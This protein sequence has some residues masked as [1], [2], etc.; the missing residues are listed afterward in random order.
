MSLQRRSTAPLLTVDRGMQVLR[1][2]RCDRAAL[3]NAELVR[4]T[5]LPKAT[6]SRL[7]STLL[8]VGYLRHV[9]GG[10]EFEL[11]TG[12]IGIGYAFEAG[13]PL[14]Q[15][16]AP[17]LQRLANTLNVSVALAVE[18]RLDMLYVGYKVGPQVAT[19]RLGVGS[20]LPLTNT[21]I[22]HAYLWGLQPARRRALWDE[23]LQRA[24]AQ[25]DA[26]AEGVRRSFADLET[27][28][29]C[30]VL[31]GH[32]AG[33]WGIA[34]PVVLGRDRMVMGLSCGNAGLRPEL[35]AE[36]RRIAPALKQAAREFEQALAGLDASH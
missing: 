23:L 18:D 20:L 35:S 2:F 26:V 3:S 19:L 33:A 14:L 15:A 1:A 31:G 25:A 10:R 13:S 36:R 24:G 22:G 21:S 34:L 6:V 7:T 4:R 30:A 29:T 8:Q 27:S 17:Q 11:A 16:A 32:A 12:C 28:G 9:P 5:G